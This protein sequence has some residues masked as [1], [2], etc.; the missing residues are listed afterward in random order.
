MA[1]CSVVLSGRGNSRNL[2]VLPVICAGDG[3][4]WIKSTNQSCNRRATGAEG[5]P[6]RKVKTS[7]NVICTLRRE[8]RKE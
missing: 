1:L 6:R 8:P 4:S 2:T 3:K 7:R 5:E